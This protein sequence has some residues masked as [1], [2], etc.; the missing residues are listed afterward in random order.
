MT[1]SSYINTIII[2]ISTE[3]ISRILLDLEKFELKFY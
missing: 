3:V 1:T 2:I